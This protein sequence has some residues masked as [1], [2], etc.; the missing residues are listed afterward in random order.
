MG[1]RLLAGLL[2]HHFILS[3]C[4]RCTHVAALKLVDIVSAHNHEAVPGVAQVPDDI[5]ED[6]GIG[7]AAADIAGADGDEVLYR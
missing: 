4:S 5:E 1:S 2:Y 3:V 6:G 7:A